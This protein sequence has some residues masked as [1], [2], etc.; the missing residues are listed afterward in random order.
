M[1]ACCT[2]ATVPSAAIADA[3]SA[4]ARENAQALYK[5]G[6]DA[7]DARDLKTA[8]ARYAAAYELFPTPAIAVALGKAETGLGQLIE[9]RQT[10]LSVERIPIKPN[11]SSFSASARDEAASLAEALTARIPAVAFRLVGVVPGTAATVAVDGFVL[12]QLAL[13]V[14]IRVN[15]GHHVAVL[16]VGRRRRKVDFDASDAET[17]EVPLPF[18]EEATAVPA[19]PS[20]AS[21]PTSPGPALQ[22]RSSRERAVR[23]AGYASLGIGGAGVA[24]AT[25]FGVLALGDR[26]TLQ[27]ACGTH[28]STCPPSTGG[29]ISALH[30]DALLSD[31]GIG[32]GIAGA[33]IGAGLLLW[34]TLSPSTAPRSVAA[35]VDFA[36]GALGGRF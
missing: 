23:L 2:A 26:S 22:A 7:R 36:H 25:A 35:Y 1:V 16:T 32:V 3:Q 27:A 8:A 24:S 5:V 20:E 29:T 21:R 30:R 28:P 18:P 15:P 14:P 17:R 6:N 4:S 31:V 33:A 13:E 10:F 34:S 11:E 12:P 19:P 9:A